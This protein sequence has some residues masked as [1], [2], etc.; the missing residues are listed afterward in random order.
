MKIC[1]RSA[2][3]EI[4]K[5]LCETEAPSNQFEIPEIYVKIIQHDKIENRDLTISD[6]SVNICSQF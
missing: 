4:G 3:D 5:Y 2:I 6:G 1:R